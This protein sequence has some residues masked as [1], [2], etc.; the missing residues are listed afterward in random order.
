MTDSPLQVRHIADRL[1]RDFTGLIDMSDLESRPEPERRQSFLSRALTALTLQDLTR[2]TPA[3]AAA[4]VIDAPDDNGID[5]I[6]VDLESSRLWLV[7]TKW[8]DKGR[9]SL[10]QASALKFQRGL[11]LLQ[12]GNYDDFNARFQKLAG[13]VDE[14]LGSPDV[15]IT[16]VVALLGEPRLSDVVGKDLQS[17]IDQLNEL[18]PLAELVVRGFSDYHRIVRTGVAEAKID[19]EARLE[20]WGQLNEPYR[21]YYGTMPV[22][23]VAS[24]YAAHGERLFGQNIRRSLGLTEVNHK[25]RTTL[26]DEPEHFWYFNN[27]ITVLCET[28]RKSQRGATN[29]AGDFTLTGASVVNGAQTVKAIYDTVRT[30]DVESPT[31]GRVWLRLISL[32]ECP[33]DFAS[34]IT[35][36]TNTQN[37]V[38]A[39][40]FVALDPVQADIRDDFVLSLHKTYVVKRGEPDPRPESGCTVVE[41]ARAMACA[42]TDA[43]F[44][45]RAKQDSSVLWETGPNGTYHALF[46]RKPSAHRVWRCVQVLRAVQEQLQIDAD[47]RD[48]RAVKVA[49]QADLL[50]AHIVFRLIDLERVDSPSFDWDTVLRQV[51]QLTSTVLDWLIH[52]VDAQFGKGSF[53]APTFRDRHRSTQLASLVTAAAASGG[54]VPELPIEYRPAVAQVRGR[55]AVNAVI[56]LVESGRVPDGTALEFRAGTTPERRALAPWLAE[57]PRRGR[58]TWINNRAKPLLWEADGKRYS[59]SGLVKDMLRMVGQKTKAV[60]GTSRWFVGGEGSLVQLAARIRSD[61]E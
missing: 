8:S 18:E 24:W 1:N 5:G 17:M 47:D 46:G 49:A 12:D 28:L 57:D 42:H 41:A 39:R 23:E 52:Y 36:A 13:P 59:P 40:D 34:A 16:A 53:V 35:E 26:R 54:E 31:T 27:G 25:L 48:G 14:V 50:T 37:Q 60:Q 29:A 6:A 7:Q 11:K 20:S 43:A 21:A 61:E 15:K 51:P 19:L 9:A 22:A 30:A 2:S 45:A 4:G 10:D 56:V 38:E 3:Q 44:A 32:E 58:A 33:P 55:R